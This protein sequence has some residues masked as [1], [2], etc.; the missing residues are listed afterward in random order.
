MRIQAR[1]RR[2]RFLAG[3]AWHHAGALPSLAWSAVRW[4]GP[5]FDL[6]P[7]FWRLLLAEGLF[8]F[9]MFV[10][11]FL[12]NLYLIQLGFQED[13]L[14]VMSGLTTAASVAGSLLSV[15]AIRRFGMRATLLASFALCAGICALRA[16]V[17]SGLELL[18]LAG[19]AGLA[20]S[21]WPVALAPSV[22][23]VANE[24]VRARAFSFICSSG[25]AIGILGSLAAGR[26]PEWIVRMHWAS[27]GVAAYRGALLAG[28]VIVALSLWPLARV[29]LTGAIA[30]RSTLRWPNPAVL[31]FLIAMAV[32]NLATGAIN[33]F[34]NVYFARM[35]VPVQNISYVFSAAQL[36]QVIAILCAP[37]FFRKLG[38]VRAICGMELGTACAMAALALAAGPVAAA[39]AYIGY[40]TFQYV[41]EP[42]MFTLLMDS[43]DAADRNSASALNFLVMFA[44]QAIGAAISGSMLA[45]FGYPPVLATAAVICVTA[46][47][48]FWL[49]LAKPAAMASARVARAA[50]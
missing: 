48:V 47:L 32:W 45:R 15:I 29:R 31:R 46:A 25:I 2:A 17:T 38:T 12:Y 36:A 43:V 7:E 34:T 41:G 20:L 13:F 44:G 11:V 4:F 18:A 26:L 21:V 22:A 40:M 28:C 33:P 49:L 14:G 10:F 23:A 30:D 35:H 37:F 3:R 1:V 5:R 9:G 39:S 19:I 50:E 27:P 8:D 42:G 16:V 6:G 24:R